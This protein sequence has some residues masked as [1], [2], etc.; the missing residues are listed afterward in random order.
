M[1]RIEITD[2][3]FDFFLQN[4]ISALSDIFHE[5]YSSDWRRL[6]I[7]YGGTAELIVK[8]ERYLFTLT[9]ALELT[10][11]GSPEPYNIITDNIGEKTLII[12]RTSCFQCL[13]SSLAVETESTFHPD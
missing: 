7:E 13:I 8:L 2:G 5:K 10:S 12:N 9:S 1:S 6:N 4:L 3:N 11:Q